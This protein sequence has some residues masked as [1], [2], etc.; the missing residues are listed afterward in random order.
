M[1]GRGTTKFEAIN[2]GLPLTAQQIRD[3]AIYAQDESPGAGLGGWVC[4]PE[5]DSGGRFSFDTRRASTAFINQTARVWNRALDDWV[6]MNRQQWPRPQWT[7]NR[8]SGGRPR[9][10][11]S[12]LVQLRDLKRFINECPV[13]DTLLASFWQNKSAWYPDCLETGFLRKQLFMTDGEWLL[14]KRRRRLLEEQ[15]DAEALPEVQPEVQPEVVVATEDAN[16]YNRFQ[17]AAMRAQ[18]REISPNAQWWYDCVVVI[19]EYLIAIGV[20][21]ESAFRMEIARRFAREILS[22][23]N[24]IGSPIETVRQELD[25]LLQA[26][27]TGAMEEPEPNPLDDLAPEPELVEGLPDELVEGF[28]CPITCEIMRDPVIDPEGNSYE[29]VAIECHLKKNGNSPL[30]RSELRKEQLVE[31]RSLKSAIEALK[32]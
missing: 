21:V 15:R 25:R 3:F 13:A 5:G 23:L 1:P 18:A 16:R 8:H 12:K 26:Q 19:R 11:G 27:L 7:Q 9:V 6:Q 10:S 29:K 4:G 22:P 32:K 20:P 28:K 14:E 31:N 30:T 17:I 2:R 24:L